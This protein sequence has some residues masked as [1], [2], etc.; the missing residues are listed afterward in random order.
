MTALRKAYDFPRSLLQSY[1]K[2]LY[3]NPLPH[4]VKPLLWVKVL[5]TTLSGH[6]VLTN[7]ILTFWVAITK[8]YSTS[9]FTNGPKSFFILY[10]DTKSKKKERE[11]GRLGHLEETLESITSSHEEKVWD[12]PGGAVVKILRSQFRE[13]GVNPWVSEPRFHVPHGVANKQQQQEVSNEVKAGNVSP[14][15]LHHW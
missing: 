7:L 3:L 14:S 1:K 9:E 10:G 11:R 4:P 13:H 6:R 5:V 15:Y 8:W 12:F 2:H